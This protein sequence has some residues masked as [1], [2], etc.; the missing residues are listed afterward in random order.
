MALLIRSSSSFRVARTAAA[1]GVFLSVTIVAG[2]NGQ[3]ALAAAPAQIEAFDDPLVT[4]S[5]WL[6]NGALIAM[7][8]YRLFPQLVLG[9]LLVLCAGLAATVVGVSPVLAAITVAV[10]LAFG[11]DLR[12]RTLMEDRIDRR[13]S[14][15]RVMSRL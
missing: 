14:Q 8:G 4:R 7:L 11:L 13:L 9:V 12:K 2:L 15:F 10:L 5:L 3:A 1:L 6:A